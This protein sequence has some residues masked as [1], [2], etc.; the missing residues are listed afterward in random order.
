MCS[1]LLAMRKLQTTI[2]FIIM[3]IKLRK[4]SWKFV[5]K[6]LQTDH[7]L[8]SLQPKGVEWMIWIRIPCQ[9]LPSDLPEQP[10]VLCRGMI[11]KISWSK[12]MQKWRKR[13]VVVLELACNRTC[14]LQSNQTWWVGTG[15]R[16]QQ[17]EY[18]CEATSVRSFHTREQRLLVPGLIELL[19]ETFGTKV[20]KK[21]NRVLCS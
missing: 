7:H 3:F 8:A 17:C 13:L 20:N 12:H 21:F 15:S 1:V 10:P 14:S 4:H 9:V 5:T 11:C 16:L 18:V 19:S 6:H 2:I